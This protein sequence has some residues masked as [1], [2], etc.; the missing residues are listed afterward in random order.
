MCMNRSDSYVSDSPVLCLRGMVG[1][2]MVVV[3]TDTQMLWVLD[4]ENDA[5]ITVHVAA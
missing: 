3:D 1:S 5:S 2:E 4:G